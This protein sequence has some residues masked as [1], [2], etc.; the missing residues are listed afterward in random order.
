VREPI[1]NDLAWL[2]DLE[3][4]CEGPPATLQSRNPRP[5]RDLRILSQRGGAA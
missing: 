2:T 4:S 1:G 5:R 3:L